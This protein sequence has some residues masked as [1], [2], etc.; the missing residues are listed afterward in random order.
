MTSLFT[1]GFEVDFD[2][3]GDDNLIEEGDNIVE[4]GNY[5]SVVVQKEKAE[6]K[7]RKRKEE[8][9]LVR[10]ER[11]VNE[12][13]STPAVEREAGE[14][15]TS[16]PLRVSSAFEEQ[17][18]GQAGHLLH[19]CP[20]ASGVITSTPCVPPRQS[21][22]DNEPEASTPQRVKL[23][24]SSPSEVPVIIE[25][26]TVTSE[27]VLEVPGEIDA[28]TAAAAS[29]DAGVAKM[30]S[31][32]VASESP[33]VATV[34]VPMVAEAVVSEIPIAIDVPRAV[35][36]SEDCDVIGTPAEVRLF[37]EVMEDVMT[38]DMVGGVAPLPEILPYS[39]ELY[40]DALISSK[41]TTQNMPPWRVDKSARKASV[42]PLTP[43][44]PAAPIGLTQEIPSPEDVAVPSQ[45]RYNTPTPNEV[46]THDQVSVCVKAFQII[47]S[48]DL[49]CTQK[50]QIAW[51]VDNA[52]YGMVNVADYYGKC[53]KDVCSESN[54]TEQNLGSLGLPL[55][56]PRF[57]ALPNYETHWYVN[58][59]YP[60]GPVKHETMTF[61]EMKDCILASEL[62]IGSCQ[63]P[64]QEGL[65]ATLQSMPTWY[66]LK[67]WVA[68]AKMDAPSTASDDIFMGVRGKEAVKVL[69]RIEV[70]AGMVKVVCA[71]HRNYVE[72]L[73]DTCQISPLE[74]DALLDQRLLLESVRIDELWF[75]DKEDLL[76]ASGWVRSQRFLYAKF[77]RQDLYPNVLREIH[78]AKARGKAMCLIPEENAGNGW[79]AQSRFSRGRGGGGYVRR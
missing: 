18:P 72:T 50:L 15:I 20:L 29:E 71:S 73:V 3:D 5:E 57:P 59:V 78:E 47:A 62:H 38:S 6:K 45:V 51:M 23:E 49:P 9:N 17:L 13:P 22:F 19:H 25:A 2:A 60:S 46:A 30:D 31:F 43:M 74:W 26:P 11:V 35:A 69:E 21:A 65:R 40:G 52:K 37:M 63:E 1:D 53:L 39:I 44:T 55:S 8:S 33:G 24:V 27:T 79:G 28:V 58:A 64:T 34:D 68:V 77:R 70:D 36:E 66:L 16:P 48:L 41:D 4:A 75:V 42:E 54:L 14:A 10:K 56:L 61:Q 7:E 67:S 12:D 76:V 32:M